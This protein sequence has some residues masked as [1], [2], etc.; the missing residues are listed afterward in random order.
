MADILDQTFPYELLVRYGP[1]GAPVGAH[2]QYLRRIT[3]DGEIIKDDVLPAQPI[4]LA[5]FPTSA[6]MG[7][8][9]R[10]ALAIVATQTAQI[11]ALNGQLSTANANLA[12]VSNDVDQLRTELTNVQATAAANENTLNGQIF[13]LGDQ[14]TLANQTI[15]QQAETIKQLQTAAAQPTGGA[16]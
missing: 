3:L 6:I 4:D 11:A 2:V 13:A 16:Q 9:C 7:D 12:T 14:L 15:E 1:G 8:T 10:D 5:G